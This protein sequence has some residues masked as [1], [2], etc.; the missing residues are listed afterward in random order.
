MT[1]AC[2][3]SAQSVLRQLPKGSPKPLA[4]HRFPEG[5]W[6]KPAGPG[7]PHACQ[8]PGPA[9][10][11]RL[12][13]V[14]APS[15]A[16]GSMASLEPQGG[17][18]EDERGLRCSVNSKRGPGPRPSSLGPW[19]GS[20]PQGLPSPAA[21]QPWN[22]TAG[23]A[24]HVP[25]NYTCHPSPGWPFCQEDPR[26]CGA[27]PLCLPGPSKCLLFREGPRPSPETPPSF[28]SWPRSPA[29]LY[30]TCWA[31]GPASRTQGPS[32]WAVVRQCPVT[33]RLIGL[34]V[35]AVAPRRH[36]VP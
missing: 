27:G 22:R 3:V 16:G 33:P 32:A 17:V 23:L 36:P 15:S 7:R 34:E 12:C 6:Q 13:W 11:A 28:L 4:P 18:N 14:S 25:C 35:Q 2:H 26:P 8:P 31:I 30:V 24:T 21:G 5:G 20:P 19:A 29:R 10:W 1:K 9:S